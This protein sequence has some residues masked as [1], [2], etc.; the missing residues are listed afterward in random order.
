M[1]LLTHNNNKITHN[2]ENIE[3]LDL[4]INH[5]TCTQNI[6]L[7]ALLIHQSIPRELTAYNYI[8]LYFKIR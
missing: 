4:S 8:S 5:S 7:V 1:T 2:F 6:I 3:Q